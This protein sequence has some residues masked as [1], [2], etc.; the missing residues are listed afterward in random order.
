MLD[1]IC[2]ETKAG[3][4]DIIWLLAIG[5]WV[6]GYKVLKT[7]RGSRMQAEKRK[8]THSD[9]VW[10]M[11]LCA[12]DMVA[13]F[14]SIRTLIKQLSKYHSTVSNMDIGYWIVLVYY[15]LAGY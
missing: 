5:Y 1:D 7:P 8:D 11:K 10:T 14:Y 4:N 15:I 2:M 3:T 9:R 13:L 12:M 6:A